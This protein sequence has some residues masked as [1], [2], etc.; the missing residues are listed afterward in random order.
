[1]ACAD[2]EIGPEAEDT[3]AEAVQAN[4]ALHD[5]RALVSALQ[6][7][8]YAAALRGE[9]SHLLAVDH[10]AG[11]DLSTLDAVHEESGA[12][13]RNT[14]PSLVLRLCFDPGM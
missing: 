4:K 3:I 10:A 12:G 11:I 8:L 6:R 5:S 7:M 2:N 1:M 9:S 13:P 14:L